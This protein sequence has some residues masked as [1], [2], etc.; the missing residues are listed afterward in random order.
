[1]LSEKEMLILMGIA[2]AATDALEKDMRYCTEFTIET[3]V[4]LVG[5]LEET[6]EELSMCSN[7]LQTVNEAFAAFREHYEG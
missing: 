6:N 5:K 4:W 2:E 1:V 7:E 3:L